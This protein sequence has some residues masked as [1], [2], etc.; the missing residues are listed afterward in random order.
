MALLTAFCPHVLSVFFFYFS[1]K[2][3]LD[4]SDFLNDARSRQ[5]VYSKTAMGNSE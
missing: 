4:F 2:L 1:K 3:L 5:S